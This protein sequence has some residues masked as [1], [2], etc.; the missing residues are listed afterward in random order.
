MDFYHRLEYS[1]V[2]DLDNAN[3]LDIMIN[4][5]LVEAGARNATLIESANIKDEGKYIAIKDLVKTLDDLNSIE[6]KSAVSTLLVYR[7]EV[8]DLAHEA[9]HNTTAMGEILGYFEPFEEDISSEERY[10]YTYTLKLAHEGKPISLNAE[11]SSSS[12]LEQAQAK[13]KLWLKYIKK[14]YPNAELVMIEGKESGSNDQL[15][16]L[17]LLVDG[18]NSKMKDLQIRESIAN[19]FSDLGFEK[20]SDLVAENDP[21]MDRKYKH[22]WLILM[23]YCINDP[24]ESLYPL[25]LEQDSATRARTEIWEQSLYENF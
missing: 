23:T 8:E 21:D 3:D 11:V 17:Q 15:Y 6:S 4:L 19:I 14:I 2:F 9:V 7:P 25:T 1:G 13:A 24:M 16:A 18:D 12:V 20:S 22:V 5:Y 10:W